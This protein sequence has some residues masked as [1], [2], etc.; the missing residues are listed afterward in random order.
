MGKTTRIGTWIQRTLGAVAALSAAREEDHD[1]HLLHRW[2]APV[3]STS[4]PR[5]TVVIPCYNYARYLKGCV[6]SAIQQEG[7]QVDVLIVDDASSDDTAQVAGALADDHPNIRVITHAENAG[8]V[9]T[10][11]EGLQAADG[12]YV[13]LISADDL[14]T[15]GSLKRSADLMEAHPEVGLVYGFPRNFT[16]ETPP[17]RLHVHSWSVWPGQ[18]WIDLSLSR[19]YSFIHS[20]EAMVR[21]SIQRD[22]GYFAPELPNSPDYEMWLRIADV[23]DV[24]RVNGPDQAYRRLHETNYTRTVYAGVLNDLSWRLK[25]A[26]RFLDNS[27][28]GHRTEARRRRTQRSIAEEALCHARDDVEAHADPAG[29]SELVSFAEQ[30]SPETVRALE[31]RALQRRMESQHTSLTRIVSAWSDLYRPVWRRVIWQRWQLTGV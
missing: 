13:V 30:V 10:F 8:M 22:V 2:H 26:G 31:W 25:A 14:L 19:T 24:G 21:N 29:S 9:A 20:P 18:R 1:H 6:E 23:S 5:V 16:G 7:V 15:P 12:T 28:P 11:N 27:R 17:A 3:A 4:W